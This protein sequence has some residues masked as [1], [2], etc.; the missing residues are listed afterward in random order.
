M[1][2]ATLAATLLGSA[3]T[4]KGVV[5]GGKGVIQAV[6]VVIRVGEGHGF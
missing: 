2:G 4:G 6:E 5:K 3:R 1:L